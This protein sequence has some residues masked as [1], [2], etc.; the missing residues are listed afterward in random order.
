MCLASI[1][2]LTS[3]KGFHIFV[4]QTSILVLEKDSHQSSSQDCYQARS[5]THYP[6]G[7]IIFSVNCNRASLFEQVNQ[8]SVAFPTI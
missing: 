2:D 6:H 8:T 1:C 7:L 5:L 4:L 3:A